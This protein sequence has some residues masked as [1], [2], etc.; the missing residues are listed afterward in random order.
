[1]NDDGF[2]IH[3]LRYYL[4]VALG[5]HNLGSGCV[6]CIGLNKHNCHPITVPLSMFAQI[7]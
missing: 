7:H 5:M 3:S 4:Y 6:V 2:L 1:M